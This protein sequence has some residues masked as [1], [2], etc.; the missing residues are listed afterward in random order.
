VPDKRIMPKDVMGSDESF[1][2]VLL[3]VLLDMYG[4]E[5]LEWEP[6][7]VRAQL[8]HDKAPITA[9]NSDKL[10]AACSILTTNLFHRSLEGFNM[11]CRVFSGE[12]VDHRWFVPATV[13]EMAWGVV[14]ARLL[15]DPDEFDKEGFSKDIELFAGKMMDDEGLRKAP[16]MLSFAIMDER[17]ARDRDEVLGADPIMMEASENDNQTSLEAIETE[18]AERLE[19]LAKQMMRLNLSEGDA[20]AP[21]RHI[22]KTLGV[23]HA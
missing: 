23:D 19:L 16:S 6:E 4:T 15:S 17:W 22:L 18:V 2:T 9:L 12:E 13:D 11:T 20:K 7:V 14:E 3:M 10:Q 21:A 8:A 5:A 1:A